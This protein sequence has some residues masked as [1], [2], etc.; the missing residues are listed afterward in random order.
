MI[1]TVTL[2]WEFANLP[3]FNLTAYFHAALSETQD[4]VVI[5]IDLKKTESA[6]NRKLLALCNSM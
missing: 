6:G 1:R 2:L 3:V 4:N 5:S